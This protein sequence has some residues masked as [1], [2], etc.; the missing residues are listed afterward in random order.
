MTT[1]DVIKAE[2]VKRMRDKLIGFN[3]RGVV[4]YYDG[5]AITGNMIP[6]AICKNCGA[7]VE[8]E[9]AKE[10]RFGHIG[11]P[12]PNGEYLRN[13]FTANDLRDFLFS[14]IDLAV[15][16]V[17]EEVM[18]QLPSKYDPMSRGE[19]LETLDDLRQKLTTFTKDSRGENG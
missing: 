18:G 4:Y 2:A 10:W 8:G 7:S 9:K 1:P 5:L 16:V 3:G 17:V 13:D 11:C 19:I 12:K 14:E 15:A 6:N